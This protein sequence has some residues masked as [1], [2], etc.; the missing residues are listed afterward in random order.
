MPIEPEARR[1]LAMYMDSRR[2]ELDMKWMDVALASR[3]SYETLRD[4]RNGT[5]GDI[6]GLTKRAIETGLRWEHGSIDRI[7]RGGEPS[8]AEPAPQGPDLRDDPVERKLWDKLTEVPELTVEQRMS[9]IRHRRRE[10]SGHD[11]PDEEPARQPA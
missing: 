2:L 4:I 7:L 6:R 11:E 10:T 8:L 5:R 3:V 1:R 9:I